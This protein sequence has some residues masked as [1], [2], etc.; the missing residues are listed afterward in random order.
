MIFYFSGTGNSRWVARQLAEATADQ[1]VDILTVKELPELTQEKQ[2][3]FVFPI[4]AW[5]AAQPMNDFLHRMP[6]TGA[7]TFAVCT[8]GA[9]A[10][11]AMKKLPYPLDSRYSIVMPGNYIVGAD[12]EDAAVIRR[13]IADAGAEIRKIAGEI[14][15]REKAY[16]VTEGPTPELRSGL[17]CKAF[18]KFARSTKKFYADDRCVGCGQCQRDCPVS[19]IHLTD[20]R[21]V[22]SGECL[23][24][25]RCI[26]SCPKQAIQFGKATEN[27]GRYTIEK[28]L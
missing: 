6:K 15:R 26:N 18:N 17:I 11:A 9:N 24:C 3:G 23:Q 5:G 13:K 25:L 28:Y 16:R 20:G 21:P 10:G 19:A 27:R 1:A 2:L 7:F 8:C 12:V 4:Y 14:Q 22:W